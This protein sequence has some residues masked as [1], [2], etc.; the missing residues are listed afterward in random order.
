MAFTANDFISLADVYCAYRKAK[1]DMFYERD[2]VTAQ[3][4]VEYEEQ[5]NEKIAG[6]H[7]RLISGEPDWMKDPSVLGT[8]SYVPKSIDQTEQGMP[9]DRFIDSD[10][11][12]EWRRLCKES[13]PEAQFRIVGRHSV[14]LHV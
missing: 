3:D 2:H 13:R 7:R 14:D 1:V 8:F 11:D 10:P 6:L 5:L 9:Q 12:A 4:F